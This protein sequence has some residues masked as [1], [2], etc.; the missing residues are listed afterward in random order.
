MQSTFVALRFTLM[1]GIGGGAPSDDNDIRLGDVVVSQPTN[2]HGGV[3]NYAFGKSLSGNEFQHTGFLT[4]PP[5]AL[6]NAVAYLKSKHRLYGPAL[7]HY[8]AEMIQ[9]HNRLQG[10][11]EYQGEKNDRLFLADYAHCGGNGSC[12]NCDESKSK[13]RPSRRS[14]NPVIHYGLVASSDIVMKDAVQRD[15]LQQQHGILCFEMEAGG[16]MNGLDCLVIRGICDYSDSHKNKRWQ[17]Y[18]AAVAAGYA[19]ELVCSL[20]I[21]SPKRVSSLSSNFE[22]WLLVLDNADDLSIIPPFWPTSERGAVLVTSQ[23]PESAHQLAHTGMEVK[24]FSPTESATFFRDQLGGNRMASYIRESRCSILQFQEA[25][26]DSSKRRQLL[27]TPNEL[28][29]PG[30]P[31][32]TVTAF[33]VTFSKLSSDALHTL[34]ILSFLDPDR[35]PET[36]LEDTE[37]RIPFLADIMSRHTI[38]R[39]L[40][41]YSLVDKFEDEASLRLHRVVAYTVSEGIDSSQSKA[42]AAFESAVILLHQYFPLQSESRSHMN[43]KWTECE[44]YIPHVLNFNERYRKL[45]EEISLTISHDFVELLYCSAWYLFE[46]GRFDLSFSVAR[47]AESACNRMDLQDHGLLLADLYSLQADMYNEMTQ[48]DKAV[49]LARQ[50]LKIKKAAV[51]AKVLDKH[52]PQIANSYMDIGVFI[53]GT[54]PRGAIR[55]HEKAIGIRERSRKYAHQQMQLLSLNYM[56]IG[57]CWW[58]IKDLDKAIVAY[59]KSLEIIK[60]LEDVAGATFAQTAWTM[61]ALGNVLIDQGKFEAAFELYTRGMKV[62]LEVLGPTHHKT[63]AC[64]NK[65]A[66]FLQKQD[67]N[68]RAIAYLRL[69]LKVH[70]RKLGVDT[71]PEIARTKYQLSQVLHLVGE[72]QESDQLKAEA[73]DLRLQLT[74]NLPQESDSQEVYDELVAYFYR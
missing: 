22:N 33:E 7:P 21:Q 37:N 11:F 38:M 34:G 30:C 26:A 60:R 18:A 50:S 44:K 72:F 71:R 52:H 49:D 55:L 17:P 19:K 36:L 12:D 46:R 43:E 58:M 53:G 51:K 67:Q 15:R 16:L 14:Q 61:T 3:I 69:S 45:S 4:K 73:Q 23:N 62:H 24:N 42:Q 35:I 57:R 6:L 5:Q 47:S 70:M 28:S 31:H 65:L 63:A 29:A 20:P 1:V 27:A 10:S 74:G 56:N 25:C 32:T 59:Q 41:R 8:L 48:A 39:D 2:G 66:W 64:Y 13:D 9:R 54:N 40:G 68:D